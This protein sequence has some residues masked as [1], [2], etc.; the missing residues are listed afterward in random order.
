MVAQTPDD[1]CRPLRIGLVAGEASGDLL[2]RGL[3]AALQ[4]R[5]PDAIFEGIGGPGMIKQGFHSLVPMERLSV[6]GLVEILGRLPELFR[7]RKQLLLHFEANPP[8]IFIGIDSPEFTIGIELRLKRLGIKTAHYVSPSVWAWRQGRIFKIAKAVDLMLTLL[9]FEARFYE[10]HNVPV[11]FVGHPLADMMAVEPDQQQARAALALPAEATVV[12]VLPGSRGGEVSMLGPVFI[13]TLRR[14]HQQRKEL[15]FVIPAANS[16]R[17]Q[18]LA[19]LLNEQLGPDWQGKY[20]VILLEGQ[21]RECMVAA[22]AVLMVSGT[23]TLEAMLAKKPMV[24]AYKLAPITYWI[25]RLLLRVKYIA[26]PN[27]LA[28]QQLVP[29]LIQDKANPE[30]LASALLAQLEPA[31]RA[32]LLDTFTELHLILRQNADQVAADAVHQLLTSKPAEL[33]CL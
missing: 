19:A 27:L 22:D 12:A 10:E 29:E 24:V 23:A 4:Q 7:I 28:D 33:S 17:M 16:A 5:Y 32:A 6:M 8:D 18:Q 14:L 11:Q 26:L 3:I 21:A 30:Q 2:G 25:M 15:R 9:P 13:A 1:S 20:P 31:R